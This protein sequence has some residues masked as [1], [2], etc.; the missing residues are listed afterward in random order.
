M[1]GRLTGLGSRDRD[2][3]GTWRNHF[4]FTFTCKFTVNVK[5]YVQ[6]YRWTCRWGGSFAAFP[7]HAVKCTLYALTVWNVNQCG[8]RGVCGVVHKV[9]YRSSS[10]ELGCLDH[11][12]HRLSC[13]GVLYRATHE[14]RGQ[15]PGP[16]GR[17]TRKRGGGPT[18]PFQHPSASSGKGSALLYGR[19]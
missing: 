2:F 6:L 17:V 15:H 1:T 16:G 3:T 5:F 12:T 10:V 14:S 7:A 4:T 13:M 11:K 9:W 18:P 8:N 19:L